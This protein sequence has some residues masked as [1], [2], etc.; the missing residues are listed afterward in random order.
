M[1]VD[2]DEQLKKILTD[3]INHGQDREKREV[4]T[5]AFQDI[6]LNDM[7]ILEHVGIDS[8][9]NMSAVAKQLHV[10]TGTL[11]IAVN[12]LVKKGY[13]ARERSEKD[14]RVV[15]ISLTTKGI[16]AYQHHERFHNKMMEQLV[17]T[18]E[19][20]ELTILLKALK[21]LRGFMEEEPS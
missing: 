20:E 18:F 15:L 3:V 13:L 14:R 5:D 19:P 10:T 17:G 16:K 1:N 11:T 4:I 9:K 2:R 12:N 7:H 8:A 21:K 6:S